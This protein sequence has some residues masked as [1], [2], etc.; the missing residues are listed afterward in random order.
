LDYWQTWI[1]EIDVDEIYLSAPP[2]VGEFGCI[3]RERVSD[4]CRIFLQE[5]RDKHADV[6]NGLVP[7][8]ALQDTGSKPRI[9][10]NYFPKQM[11]AV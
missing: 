6:R 10:T 2:S 8:P 4:T 5:F 9:D 7:E 3:D 1:W 11:E